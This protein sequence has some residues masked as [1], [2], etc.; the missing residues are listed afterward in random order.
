MR[1]IKKVRAKATYLFRSIAC[2]N[3][4]YYETLADAKA[5]LALAQQHLGGY[6]T[7]HEYMLSKD[8]WCFVCRLY[9]DKKIQ[10]AYAKKRKKYN[11]APKELATWR[12]ISEQ[13]R[14]FLSAYVPDYNQRTG[15][16]GTLVSRSYERFIFDTKREAMRM[17]KR[18]RRRVVGMGQPKKKYRA[19]K[20][21][22]RIPK[23]LGKG[24]IYLSSRRKKRWDGKIKNLLEFPLFQRLTNKVLAQKLKKTVKRTKKA[25]N[26]PI[27]DI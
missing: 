1:K 23:N 6:M 11:K 12:I 24:A 26:T 18:I 5:F 7:I 2:S 16:K 9:S 15:R 14:L 27:P 20:G 25:H 13:V 8:G 17:I 10:K 4:V 19:K 21:H 3:T 22:Y